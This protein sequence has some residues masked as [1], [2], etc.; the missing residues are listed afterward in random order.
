MGGSPIIGKDRGNAVSV[1]DEDLGLVFYLKM[2]NPIEATIGHPSSYI[3]HV[4]LTIPI[5]LMQMPNTLL[6]AE[7]PLH[8]LLVPSRLGKWESSLNYKL[9]ATSFVH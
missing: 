8:L 9:D 4:P 2:C 3:W 6:G 7:M 5:K 1:P